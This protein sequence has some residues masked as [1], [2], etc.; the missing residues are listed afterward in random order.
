MARINN[1]T[2]ISSEKWLSCDFFYFSQVSHLH[3]HTNIYTSSYQSQITLN[4]CRKTLSL[5]TLYC[6]LILVS[7]FF[8]FSYVCQCLLILTCIVLIPIDILSCS[9]SFND[10]KYYC[11]Y[12]Y[13]KYLFWAMNQ[14]RF[15]L[16]HSKSFL[17]L[18]LMCVFSFVF[19]F[20]S[21]LN[22][23]CECISS[24]QQS[25]C[26]IFVQLEIRKYRVFSFLTFVSSLY[27]NYA[28]FIC[29]FPWWVAVFTLFGLF[30]SICSFCL[31]FP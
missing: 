17:L 7:F 14:Q 9:F 27:A 21:S 25:Q 28:M 6:F 24:H 13:Y 3:A 20:T 18:L 11:L 2:I 1:F 30:R 12:V 16:M 4:V 19:V 8:V 26:F 22:H 15:S 29:V 5:K 23:L 10:S 31:I